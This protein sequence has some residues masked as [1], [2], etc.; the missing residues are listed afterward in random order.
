ML[1]MAHR[2]KRDEDRISSVSECLV[3]YIIPIKNESGN[4][5]VA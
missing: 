3:T 1:I 5:G 4:I 2:C